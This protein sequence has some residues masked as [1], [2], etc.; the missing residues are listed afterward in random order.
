MAQGLVG[1]AELE[2]AENQRLAPYACHSSRSRGRVYP[3]AMSTN[4]TCYQQDRDRIIHSRAFR[5][6]KHKTQVFIAVEGDHYRTRLT[7]TLEVAQVARHLARLLCL[8]ED[9]CE[10]IALAHDLGHPPFG[11]AGEA[12]LSIKMKDHGGFEHNL[13]SKRI[14]EVLESRYPNYPGLN[15]SF[16]MRHGLMKHGG[17]RTDHPQ[18]EANPCVSL[19]AQ[20]VDLADEIAYTNHD[21]DDGLRS[22]LLKFEQLQDLPL[23]R[24]GQSEIKK[25]HG[26]MDEAAL[27]HLSIGHIIRTLIQ[28]VAETTLR[29]VH[30]AKIETVDHIYATQRL[31]A[32]S[33]ERFALFKAAK[34]FLMSHFYLHPTVTE[35][36]QRHQKL[37]G[38][39]FDYYVEH[40][41]AGTSPTDPH[42]SI[43]DY[44]SGMTDTYAESSFR[45]ALG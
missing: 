45:A 21:L 37:L 28:D 40:P 29:N 17:G 20:L 19:E 13:Q 16:E 38:E 15:L 9:L 1:R 30:A 2:A 12:V 4:R 39:L 27:I 8:N 18:V 36:N 44:V 34:R 25:N 42:R 14:V 43:C 31:A 10:C 6:L 5:R 3:E 24:E 22:G 41:P 26:S 35:A 11:H 32:F 33:S 7:H 23:W